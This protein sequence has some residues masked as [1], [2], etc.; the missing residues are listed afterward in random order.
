MALRKNK[1]EFVPFEEENVVKPLKLFI[2]IVPFGQ[3]DNF[4][5]L[6]NENG[7]TFSFITTGEGTGR[8]YLPGLLTTDDLK[9][10]IIFTFSKKENTEAICK[11]LEEK[12]STTK[13]AKGV[14]LSIK[15][16]SVAGVSVYRFISNIRKVKKV[17]AND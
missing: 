15:L 9:K 7:S 14:S 17:N 1:K 10:Q 12:F 13:S 6:L 4:V 5:K 2:S 3:A 16:S 11:A 8:N